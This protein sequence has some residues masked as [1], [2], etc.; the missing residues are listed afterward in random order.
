MDGLQDMQGGYMKYNA[1]KRF[2]D[3]AEYQSYVEFK[4]VRNRDLHDITDR[5][6]L[7]R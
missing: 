4:R 6:N 1:L 5:G 7:P 3:T 2:T